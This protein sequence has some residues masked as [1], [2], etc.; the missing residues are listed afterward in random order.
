MMKSVWSFFILLCLINFGCRDAGQSAGKTGAVNN[1]AAVKAAAPDQSAAEAKAKSGAFLPV[2]ETNDIAS[3]EKTAAQSNDPSGAQENE[4]RTTQKETGLI[5]K[6]KIPVKDTSLSADHKKF[7]EKLGN[8]SRRVNDLLISRKE[9]LKKEK[10]RLKEGLSKL[11]D[12]AAI[13]NKLP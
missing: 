4:S 9:T 6:Y 5:G 12:E 3:T 8:V 11:I 1:D 13:H 2:T 10:E 7:D